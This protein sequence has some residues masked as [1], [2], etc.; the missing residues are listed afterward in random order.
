MSIPAG[1]LYTQEH[2]WVRVDGDIATVGIT[3]FAQS[4]LGDIVFIDISTVGQSVA[5]NDV[6]GSVEA[7]KTV[8]DLFMP[9]SGEV[10]ELNAAL[11]AS[12]EL[13]N[14]DPFGEGWLVKVRISDAA[15]LAGL[16]SAE[17]YAAHTA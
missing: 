1:L 4:N 13:V 11:D 2:E 15:E 3:D 17:A 8:A 12:P 7:V 9:V 10:L 5:Q 16:M 14:S 6:F